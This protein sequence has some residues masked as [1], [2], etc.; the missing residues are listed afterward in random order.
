MRGF[1]CDQPREQRAPR[2]QPPEAAQVEL[3]GLDLAVGGGDG[4]DQHQVPDALAAENGQHFAHR[5]GVLSERRVHDARQPR[6]PGAHR[7]VAH[8]FAFDLPERHFAARCQELD[9][10]IHRRKPRQATGDAQQVLRRRNQGLAFIDRHGLPPRWAAVRPD[11]TGMSG[12][13][14]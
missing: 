1:E 5:C 7:R 3:A 13:T 2:A 9:P 14:G 4:G 6:Q 12:R 8:D 11:M 10:R